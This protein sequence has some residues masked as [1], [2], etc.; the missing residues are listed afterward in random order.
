M[1][2]RQQ[3]AVILELKE[4]QFGCEKCHIIELGAPSVSSFFLSKSW[5]DAV[6]IVVYV[7]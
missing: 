2:S 4:R 3:P 1:P 6:S 5:A 7:M